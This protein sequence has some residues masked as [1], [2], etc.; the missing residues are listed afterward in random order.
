MSLAAAPG[1]RTSRIPLL[2]R[3][4]A[5]RRYW[6][7]Q[8]VSLPSPMPRFRLAV[9]ISDCGDL[10]KAPRVTPTAPRPDG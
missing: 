6:G 7:A 4:T 10:D 3:E 1:R 5:F 8:T 2:L 9:S